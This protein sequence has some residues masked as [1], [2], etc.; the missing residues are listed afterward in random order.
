MFDPT[1]FLSRLGKFAFIPI[2]L[3]LVL[4]AAWT[5][6]STKTWVAHAI[7]VPGKVIEMVRVRDRE[8]SGYMFAPV[9]RFQTIEGSTVE[10]ESGFRSNPPAYHTGQTVS[11]LYDP[12]EPHSAAIRG[13]FSLWLMP[14]ILG[15]IGTI[16]LTVGTAMVVMSAWAAKFFEQPA[17]FSGTSAA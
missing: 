12:D 16:F 5:V 15:F 14:I 6:W 11:V 4:G 9:V 13:F 2:G 3:M 7:E 1:V 17:A 10:F 8:D